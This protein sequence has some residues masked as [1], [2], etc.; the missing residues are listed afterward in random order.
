[1]AEITNNLTVSDCN[2][3][4]INLQET[5]TTVSSDTTIYGNDYG[6][7]L[8]MVPDFTSAI[9]LTL[10]APRTEGVVHKVKYVGRRATGANLQIDGNGTT[11][12]GSVHHVGGNSGLNTATRFNAT[13]DALQVNTGATEVDLTLV[14]GA[15]KWYVSGKVVSTAAVSGTNV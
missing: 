10:V 5:P 7:R 3:A 2:V 4:N 15:S 1:M 9:K 11:L 12:E 13:H 8:I 14:S 6:N